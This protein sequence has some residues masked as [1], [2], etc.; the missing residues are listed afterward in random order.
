MNK[1]EKL[2]KLGIDLQDARRALKQLTNYSE[3]L[4][5]GDIKQAL[6]TAKNLIKKRLD[7]LT[8]YEILCNMTIE[9]KLENLKKELEARRE[10]FNELL[11]VDFLALT[12]IE[13]YDYS[14]CLNVAFEEYMSVKKD[15]YQLLLNQ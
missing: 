10:R 7:L 8:D 4:I 3:T 1:E 14:I 15:I 2:V 13:Y 6:T 9:E 5:E 12:K 11:T